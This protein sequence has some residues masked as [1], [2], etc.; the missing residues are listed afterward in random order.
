MAR[1]STKTRLRRRTVCTTSLAD[2]SYCVQHCTLTSQQLQLFN[3][4]VDEDW[5]RFCTKLCSG[6]FGKAVP[7]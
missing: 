2:L 4:L 3:N 7:F 6:P 1:T 5:E